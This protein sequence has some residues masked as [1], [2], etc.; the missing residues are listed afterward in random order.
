MRKFPHIISCCRLTKH[1]FTPLTIKRYNSNTF[2]EKAVRFQKQLNLLNFGFARRPE[3]ELKSGP[4][5]PLNFAVYEKYFDPSFDRDTFLEGCKEALN[6]V[7]TLTFS[8]DFESLE[9]LL[10]KECLESVKKFFRD[11]IEKESYTIEG[12]FIEVISKPL[13]SNILTR[14]LDQ[15]ETK[16]VVQVQHL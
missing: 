3:N 9:N 7:R 13:F 12:E 5:L 8:Q 2:L 4:L 10:T 14:W 11:V 15:I 16:I 1:A 6:A